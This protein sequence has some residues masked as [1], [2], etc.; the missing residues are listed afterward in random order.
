[1]SDLASQIQ[2]RQQQ[3]QQ[4][5]LK[6]Y[7]VIVR[8][9]ATGGKTPPIDEVERTLS[10]AGRSAEDLR[11]DAA[12]YARRIGWA[13]AVAKV[14]GYDTER[15]DLEGRVEK[16][17]ASLQEAQ[18]RHAEVINPIRV[19]MAE[20]TEDER[21]AAVARDKLMETAP[22]DVTERHAAA[23]AKL[24]DLQCRVGA[25]R[26]AQANR[27]EGKGAMEQ[28]A[29]GFSMDPDGWRQRGQALLTAAKEADEQLPGL[30]SEIEQQ[31]A[32]VE[33]LAA[34]LLKV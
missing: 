6:Q 27:V 33:T 18:H 5:A 26:V 8:A 29:S 28:A 14:K 25:H 4:A 1:M 23:F 24:N 17:N 2:E 10:D 7:H 22:A 3:R 31:E 12:A 30:L 16:A 19:R 13:A 32:A 21:L 9:T 11:T 20:I 34:E 15:K